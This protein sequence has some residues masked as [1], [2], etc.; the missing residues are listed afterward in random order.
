MASTR[1]PIPKRDRERAGHRAKAERAD[2]VVRH[3]PVAVPPPR[4]SWSEETRAYYL[5]LADSA[6]AEFYEPA[7]WQH[8]LATMELLEEFYEKQGTSKPMSAD[9]MKTMFYELGKL[10][11]TES[12][13]RRLRVEGHRPGSGED[14]DAPTPSEGILDR[15]GKAASGGRG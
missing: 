5:G 9:R 15:F 1:G 8:A 11:A 12:D 13:R 14:E 7:D 10:G 3:E 2:S 6:M 4:E